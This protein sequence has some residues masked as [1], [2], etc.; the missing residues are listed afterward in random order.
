MNL[1]GVRQFILAALIFI[2][3]VYVCITCLDRLLGVSAKDNSI[4]A[5]QEQ[6][7]A[8]ICAMVDT[9]LTTPGI[10]SGNLFLHFSGFD[11]EQSDQANYISLVYYRA[12]YTRYP[13]RIFVA[14]SETIINN[15]RDIGTITFT[16][17]R[18]WFT[19]HAVQSMLTFK[20]A[21]DGS[22]Q[23][24]IKKVTNNH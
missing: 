4:A 17:D 12:V 21:A 6:T 10:P 22:V 16:P 5:R 18:Q 7:T 3:F 20:R 14:D 2:L 15:G 1:A 19:A 8:E 13:Q 11:T 23:A 9:V 24:E